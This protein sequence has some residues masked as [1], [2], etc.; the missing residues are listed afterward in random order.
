MIR[1]DVLI[2]GGGV[3]GLMSGWLLAR[4]GVAATVIDSGMPAATDAAAGMLAPS[5]EGSLQ[6]GAALAEFSRKSLGRWP[7]LAAALYERSG[8]DCD[9]QKGVL[10]VA[11]D[12]GE[13]AAFE[14]DHDGGLLLRREEVLALEPALSPRV[15]GGR[16]AA[17]DGQVDPRLVRVALA[18]ALL[19]DGGRL[20]RGKKIVAVHAGENGPARVSTEGGETIEAGHVVIATGARLDGL[21]RLPPGAVFPVK[22]E[23]LALGR[24]AG[25]PMRVVRTGRAYLCPKADGRVVVGATEIEGDWSLTTDAAR[26]D[27]LRKGAC[28]AFSALSAAPEISRW[29][30]I[31][32]STR[33]G[34]PIIGGAAEAERVIFALGHY[35]NG[36]LLAPA[37]ADAVVGAVTG[38]GADPLI[39]AF[40][41]A[42]FNELGVS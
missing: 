36:V 17:D 4:A 29:A 31:R 33:D 2:I 26:I 19:N 28:A 30:G 38:E 42:R 37:T 3:I 13:A 5:F 10:S 27:A 24:V 39:A 15:L 22:G 18:R 12:E 35:R 25:S 11:F 8:V 9:F 16:F 21:T 1:S 7:A 23:A 6:Q 41:A 34:A 14:K 40:S 20:L 32:P